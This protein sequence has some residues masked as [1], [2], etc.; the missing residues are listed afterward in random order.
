M[1]PNMGNEGEPDFLNS[2]FDQ[3]M[4]QQEHVVKK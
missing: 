2:E 3:I 4:N 1:T